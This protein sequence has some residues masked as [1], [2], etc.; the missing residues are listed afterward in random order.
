MAG[1][2]AV[3]AGTLGRGSRDSE[4]RPGRQEDLQSQGGDS[5]L[6]IIPLAGDGGLSATWEGG[7]V[8]ECGGV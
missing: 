8:G 4:W 1:G 3:A 7:R 5:G 6:P 2:G